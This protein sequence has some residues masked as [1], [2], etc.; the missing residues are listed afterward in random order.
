M[1]WKD[2]VVLIHISKEA[3]E[4]AKASILEDPIWNE[5]RKRALKHVE[6]LFLEMKRKEK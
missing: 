5:R 3:K 6:R 2:S 1:A 4:K